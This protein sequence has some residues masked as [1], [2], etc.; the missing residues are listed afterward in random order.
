[1]F[2]LQMFDNLPIDV[3]QICSPSETL[4]TA[5]ANGEFC[6]TFTSK[7][8]DGPMFGVL[9]SV[10][11]GIGGVYLQVN[12]EKEL[13]SLAERWTATK[14]YKVMVTVIKPRFRANLY[15]KSRTNWLCDEVE[16]CQVLA[17]GVL[18]TAGKSR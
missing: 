7:F 9:S 4:W 13:K 3:S 6:N 17:I 11:M 10:L 1:M 15:M 12:A 8:S 5:N 14:S 2:K 18:G 16:F